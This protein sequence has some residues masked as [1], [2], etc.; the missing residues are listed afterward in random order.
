[1]EKIFDPY[2]STKDQGKGTG[3]GLYMAK[4]IIEENMGGKIRATN[5]ENGACF[6]ITL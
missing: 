6:T 2:F 3:I 1:M 4:M 5:Q